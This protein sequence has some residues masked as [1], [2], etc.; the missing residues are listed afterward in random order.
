MHLFS[1]NLRSFTGPAAY[2]EPHFTYLDRSARAPFARVRELIES[3]L[4]DYPAFHR[5]SL[6][7]RLRNTDN[8]HFDAAF[9]ELYLHQLLHRLGCRIRVSPRVGRT[10]LKRPDFEITCPDGKRWLLEATS[11]GDLSADERKAEARLVTALNTLN[12][13][14][15]KDYFLDVST[16]GRPRSPIPGKQLRHTVREFLRSLNYDQIREIYAQQSYDELPKTTFE[17]DGCKLRIR[18]V[19]KSP[20]FRDD[21]DPDSRAIGMISA[22]VRWI[23]SRSGIRDAIRRKATRYGRLRRP[24]VVAVNAPDQS[25]GL[26]D[27][28]EALLGK[29]QLAFSNFADPKVKPTFT[30]GV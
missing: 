27:V 3:W 12:R 6:V 25:L 19:P 20:A 28:M 18:V 4:N 30:S 1:E 29:E 22:G 2:A 23:D 5:K 14:R 15:V 9:F 13:L 21:S 16:R 17:H 26:T 10:T 24:L 11:S 7:R 8:E